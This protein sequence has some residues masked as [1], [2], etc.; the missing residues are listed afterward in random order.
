MESCRICLP[1]TDLFHSYQ[2]CPTSFMLLKMT[3]LPSLLK[4][5]SHCSVSKYH[6]FF[7]YWFI[8]LWTLDNFSIS[9]F[10]YIWQWIWDCRYLLDIL[11]LFPL[12]VNSGEWLLDVRKILLIV[13]W[14]ISKLSH[15]G[16]AIFHS[17]QQGT[18]VTLLHIL[19][20][21]CYFIFIK[22]IL[23]G[24]ISFWPGLLITDA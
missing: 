23:K 19:A 12:D 3:G 6:I 4:T 17:Y 18:N 13:F 9:F 20:N 22:I 7:F 15:N 10:L 16:Y 11:V 21:I 1:V 5:E 2:C 8:S 14:G 24:S